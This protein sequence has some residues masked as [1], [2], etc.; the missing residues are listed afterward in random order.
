METT[1]KAESEFSEKDAITLMENGRNIR[2]VEPEAL[3]T[4]W[5]KWAHQQNVSTDLRID[6]YKVLI[7]VFTGRKIS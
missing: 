4:A 1:V 6:Y 7:A 3:D 2:G 5:E